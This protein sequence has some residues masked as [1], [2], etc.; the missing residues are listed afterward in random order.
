[1]ILSSELLS[2]GRLHETRERG[3]DIDGRV[4][5]LVVELTIDK[6]LSFRNITRQI[7]DRVSD[8]YTGQVG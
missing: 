5:L 3:Q 2:N 8:I 4:N 7:G 6:D 1:M